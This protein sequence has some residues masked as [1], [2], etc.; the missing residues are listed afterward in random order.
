MTLF[1]EEKKFVFS[2]IT[3]RNSSSKIL[4]YALSERTLL[5][6]ASEQDLS[7]G[8]LDD[9][10]IFRLGGSIKNCLETCTFMRH[11][12]NLQN[13]EALG[14]YFSAPRHAA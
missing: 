12:H 4:W 13:M 11:K 2:D 3:T 1:L 9:L 5:E 10:Q 6:S 14:A 8:L 7:E